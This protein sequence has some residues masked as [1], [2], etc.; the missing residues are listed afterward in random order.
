MVATAL[1]CH[2]ASAVH[3]RSPVVSYHYCDKWTLL[4]YHVIPGRYCGVRHWC[5]SHFTQLLNPAL[6]DSISTLST[7]VLSPM[8]PLLRYM[9]ASTALSC[10]IASVVHG[11]SP[12]V[13]YHW[14][15][16]YMDATALS[17][18]TTWSLLR[19]P[20]CHSHLVQ[21][22]NP[23]LLDSISTPRNPSI[24]VEPLPTLYISLKCR[25]DRFFICGT[26]RFFT[27]C[28]KCCFFNCGTWSSL[29]QRNVAH[30]VVLQLW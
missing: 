28:V 21:L 9:V 25:I 4:R 1:S 6:L 27:A 17:C 12:V 24:L 14:L 13:S 30:L 23:A 11:R 8:A 16:R 10:H 29:L 20:S 15:L 22:L 26:Y 3:G 7:V 5:R 19:C 2:I 18:H